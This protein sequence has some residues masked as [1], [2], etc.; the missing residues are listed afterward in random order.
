MAAACVQVNRVIVCDGARPR[1]LSPERT[2]RI[3][4]G[5][6]FAT[7]ART[8]PIPSSRQRS[9]RP[10]TSTRASFAASTTP[11]SPGSIKRGSVTIPTICCTRSEARA[12]SLLA[13]RRPSAGSAS[14][15]SRRSVVPSAEPARRRARSPTS[16]APLLRTASPPGRA[17]A[18]AP[19]VR[20]PTSHGARSSRTRAARRARPRREAPAAP[21]PGRGPRPARS[22]ALP[23]PHR[24]PR[25]CTRRRGTDAAHRERFALRGERRPSQPRAPRS[26]GEADEDQLPPGSGRQSLGDREQVG[27]PGL[28]SDENENGAQAPAAGCS[29]AELGVLLQD[30]ALEL[31]EAR[32]RLDPELGVERLARRAVDVE[33]LRLPAGSVQ[34]PH[35][36]AHETLVERMAWTSASSSGRAVRSG[37]ARGLH[38]CAARAPRGGRLRGAGLP[39]ARTRRPPARRGLPRARVPAPRRAAGSHS[40]GL[41][42]VPPRSPGARSGAGRAG[43][44][45]SG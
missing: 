7:A 13:S 22:R 44:G 17:P 9:E 4:A 43:R 36:R 16:R 18:P 6:A 30:R 5:A 12:S 8:V 14:V 23:P 39:A 2:K 41:P 21:P 27:Q 34:G 37:R 26:R 24:P 15:P 35:E 25:R 1:A 42:R 45:R 32:R 28:V 20:R 33:R 3:G 19:A 10:T 31:A 40:R 38:R 29:S 11:A